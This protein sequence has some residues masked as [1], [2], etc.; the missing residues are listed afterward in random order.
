LALGG[1]ITGLTGLTAGTVYFLSPSSAGALTATEPTTLGQVS[2][3]LLVADTTTSGYLFNFR[4]AVLADTVG[5]TGPTGPTGVGATGG[6]GPT[7][8]TGG[9]GPTGP[10]GPTGADSTVTGPTGPTGTGAT[11]P[12]G[13]TGPTVLPTESINFVIDGGG[14]AITTGIKGD[15]QVDFAC[16][17]SSWTLLADQSGSI[18]V[19]IWRD[20][21]GNFPPTD[22]DAMPGAGKEP[23]I[24]T[25]TNATD[26]TITDWTSD[27]ITAGDILRINV[28]SCTTIQ[29]CTLVLKVVRV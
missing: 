18:V 26:T 6:T 24:T 14:S 16:T 20:T 27:D 29:R 11:G 5:A 3:P 22:A 25:A 28:D 8:G 15:L 10:T 13:P 12:T 21:L 23:T 1:R 19:D 2:K 7:G 17:I 4:G 9:T